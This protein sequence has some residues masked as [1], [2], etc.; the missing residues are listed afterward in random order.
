MSDE[1]GAFLVNTGRGGIAVEADLVRAIDE[2]RIAGIGI[3][4]YE[5]EPL[6]A[7]HPY[8]HSKFPDRI[9]LS[10]HIAWYSREA[11]ARLAHEMAE[12][13]RKGW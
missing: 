3:D 8:L 11:R 12:N 10:P 7:D 6:Q 2:E 13:I 5:K 1:A 9:L 4:V